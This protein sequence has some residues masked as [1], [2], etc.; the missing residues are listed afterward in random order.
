MNREGV[1]TPVEGNQDKRRN[2]YFRVRS[3]RDEKG[4][5]IS[6][7]YGK[8]YGEFPEVTYYLNPV[9]NDHNVEFDVNRNLFPKLGERIKS[10][11]HK[12]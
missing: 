11:Y 4:N 8:I 7:Y 10:Q 6:G 5:I 9:V 3:K 2:Y 12:Y 1:G